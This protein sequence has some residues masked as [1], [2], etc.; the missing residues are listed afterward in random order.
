MAN[1][2]HLT[3]FAKWVLSFMMLSGRLELFTQLNIFHPAFWRR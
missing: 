2:A 1:Y 3:D